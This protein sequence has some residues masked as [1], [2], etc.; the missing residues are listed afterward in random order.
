MFFYILV[1]VIVFENNGNWAGLLDRIKFEGKGYMRN[2]L[3]LYL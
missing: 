2:I 3:C 1:V